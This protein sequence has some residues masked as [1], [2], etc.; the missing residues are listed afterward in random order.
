[1]SRRVWWFPLWKMAGVLVALSASLAVHAEDW[2]GRPIKLVVPSTAGS[3]P[4]IFARIL[5]DAL[6]ARIGATVVV[7]NK[8]GAGGVVA[9]NAIAKAPPD[10]Y[11]VGITPPGPLGAD[12]LLQKHL[13]YDLRKDLA[14]VTLA[15]TQANVLVV[16]STLDVKDMGQLTRLLSMNP[17]KYT[18]A[19]IGAG[20]VNRL[21]MELVA[22]RSGTTMTRV[23]YAGTPQA[24]LAVIGGEVDMACLPEQA[25]AAQVQAGKLHALA[26]ASAKRSSVL[27]SVPT[28][29]ELGMPGIEAD[30]W[31]GIIAP[32]G[33]P[34]QIVSR[35]RSEIAQV[36]SQPAIRD[37][38]H[39]NFLEVVAS[40]PEAFA[41][42]VRDDTVRWRLLIGTQRIG[43]D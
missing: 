27:S 3:T 43:M 38:L 4:D 41:G 24:M 21:C 26:V 2:P 33:T 22:Q 14:L 23:A 29:K 35:L 37:R 13:P 20:S 40:T 15:V 9:V 42:T 30:S 28:L 18:Y 36:L 8:P 10:G 6:R 11:T 16:R 25:V 34:A 19:A 17:R 39:A 12:T 32:A 5:A 7:D 1:M 31:M